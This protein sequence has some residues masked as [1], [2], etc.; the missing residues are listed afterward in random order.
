MYREHRDEDNVSIDCLQEV[1]NNGNSLNH[2]PQDVV[3]VAHRRWSFMRDGR[4]W[5]FQ[6]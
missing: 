5:K 4:A 3:R 6:L 1:K 2:W